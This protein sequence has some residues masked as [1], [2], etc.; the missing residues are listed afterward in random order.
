MDKTNFIK[1]IRKNGTSLAV[2]IP[3]EIIELLGL[4]EGDFLNVEIEKL[5]KK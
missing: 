2:N 4:K 3:S 1:V 5:I